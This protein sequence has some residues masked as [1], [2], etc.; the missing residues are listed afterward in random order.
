MCYMP[1]FIPESEGHWREHQLYEGER[2]VQILVSVV[3]LLRNAL[4]RSLLHVL[5]PFTWRVVLPV[6]AACAACVPCLDLVLQSRSALA[7]VPIPMLS[8]SQ[9]TSSSPK[10]NAGQL[11]SLGLLGGPCLACNH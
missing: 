5:W 3:K 1:G 10:E 8:Y 9:A 11:L 2:A 4:N 7:P 6:N